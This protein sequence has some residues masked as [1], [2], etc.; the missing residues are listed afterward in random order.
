MNNSFLNYYSL[1]LYCGPIKKLVRES[2]SKICSFTQQETKNPKNKKSWYAD[3]N[4]DKASRYMVYESDD[5]W[6]INMV[7]D[8][9]KL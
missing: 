3:K 7:C 1:H 9:N 5:D 8:K 4:Y 2:Y 6:N